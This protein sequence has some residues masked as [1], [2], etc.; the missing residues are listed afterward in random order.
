MARREVQARYDALDRAFRD[1]KPAVLD[2]VMT[3][4]FSGESPEGRHLGQADAVGQMRGLMRQAT[5]AQWPRRIVQFRLEGA[6]A[7]ATVEGHFTGDLRGPDR[8][9][10]RTELISTVEDTWTKGPKG[11]QIRRSR[12]VK[13]SM[14]RDGKTI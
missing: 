8:K 6:D 4:D 1:H 7:I 5:H 11:W 12:V 13:V 3:A 14:K 2:D 10:H 9:S